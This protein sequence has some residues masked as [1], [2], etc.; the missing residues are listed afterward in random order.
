MYNVY[1]FN[2]NGKMNCFHYTFTASPIAV[3][4]YSEVNM[5]KVTNLVGQKVTIFIFYFIGQNYHKAKSHE[6][7]KN[8]ILDDLIRYYKN[9]NFLHL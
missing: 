5:Q 7:M 3:R 2:N 6:I 9:T 8:K 1:L 4:I